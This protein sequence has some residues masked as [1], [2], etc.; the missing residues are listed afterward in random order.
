MVLEPEHPDVVSSFT[1]LANLYRTQG[2]YA[3]AE[4]LYKK[5]LEQWSMGRADCFESCT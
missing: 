3:E 2:C 5:T 4:P 1:S